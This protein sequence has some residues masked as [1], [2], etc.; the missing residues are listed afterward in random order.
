MIATEMPIVEWLLENAS[1][2]VRYRTAL[3]LLDN[4][5]SMDSYVQD[6]LNVERVHIL[7]EKLDDFG[8]ITKIDNRTFNSIHKGAGLEGYAAKLLDY[9]LNKDIKPF[10]DRMILF[11]QYI[12]NEWLHAAME[13]KSGTDVRNNWA[14]STARILSSYFVQAGYEFP[15]LIEFVNLRADALY[16]NA[17]EMNFDV[18]YTQ[19]AL[20]QM[21]KRPPAWQNRPVL[22]AEFDPG[23]NGKPLPHIW[24][25]FTLAH[26]RDGNISKELRQKKNSIIDYVLDKRFQ[27]LPEGY[28]LV[29][30]T[31]NK[32]YYGCGWNPRLPGLDGFSDRRDKAPAVLYAD[33]MSHFKEARGSAWFKRT[34]D[35]LETFRTQSGTYRFPKEY[36]NE[37][38]DKGF[39]TG[40]SMGLGENRRNR[41]ALEIESSFRMLLLNKRIAQCT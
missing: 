20:Q 7:L 28:G 33:L 36:L 19:S 30:F 5:I 17:K 32:R 11:R 23:G 6:L 27:A 3:E 39:V 12:N 40:Q 9:G 18:Y 41:Q 37:S 21:P 31:A 2:I 15:D 22:K 25:I 29:F 34:L 1:P 8:P 16:K 38:K 14:L 26:L 4:S 13:S 35:H 24:D 10:H